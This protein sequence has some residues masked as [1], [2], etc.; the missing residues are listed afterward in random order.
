MASERREEVRVVRDEGMERRQRVVEYK[1]S[2]QHV[3][4]SRISQLIWFVVAVVAILLAL[5]FVLYLI[6]ANPASG[7]AAFIYNI[8]NVLVAPFAGLVALPT[9]GN[10]SIV[11][12]ISLIAL[13]VY[14]L[15]GWGIVQLFRIIFSDTGGMRRVKTVKRSG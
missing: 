9:M 11:D 15:L 10:G 14:T 13:V 8:T 3:L 7:F 2:T 6:A 1:P 5:R 4:V 12:V